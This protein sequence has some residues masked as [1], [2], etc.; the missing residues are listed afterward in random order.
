MITALSTP[1]MRITARA[2]IPCSISGVLST[3]TT[4][5]YLVTPEALLA[6]LLISVTVPENVSSPM[7]LTVIWAVCPSSRDRILVSSTL[8]VIFI[9]RSGEIVSREISVS[10]SVSLS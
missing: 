9:C 8:I 5:E 6:V 7:E 1:E 4:A 2:D 3:V 10:Y